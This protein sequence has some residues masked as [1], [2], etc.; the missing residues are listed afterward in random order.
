[1][2]SHAR[3]RART[4]RQLQAEATPA[5]PLSHSVSVRRTTAHPH[6]HSRPIPT[7]VPWSMRTRP[8][9]TRGR[10]PTTCA[11]T[12][13][14]QGPETSIRP[15]AVPAMVSTSPRWSPLPRSFHSSPS[16]PVGTRKPRHAPCAAKPHRRRGHHAPPLLL[17]IPLNAWR[18]TLK[19][20]GVLLDT[21]W[22]IC[23]CGRSRSAGSGAARQSLFEPHGYPHHAALQRIL[24]R[25]CAA[26][27]ASSHAGCS[28]A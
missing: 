22:A 1:L 21:R 7:H 4:R 19:P 16:N 2:S 11:K 5:A 9:T 23:G 24:P 12:P 10:K 14:G 28:W 18:C 3:S 8:R 25:S 17:G 6:A 27:H 13:L 20:V 15:A 26:G